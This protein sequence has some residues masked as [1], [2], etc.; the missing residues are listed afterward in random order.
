MFYRR[1]IFIYDILYNPFEEISIIEWK[2]HNVPLHCGHLSYV[3]ECEIRLF[4]RVTFQQL[5]LRIEFSEI[6]AYIYSVYL[7]QTPDQ[8]LSIENSPNCSIISNTM[9][10]IAELSDPLCSTYQHG[11]RQEGF[12]HLQR[13]PDLTPITDLNTKRPCVFNLMVCDVTFHPPL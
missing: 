2:L 12:L 3:F 13:L 4:T 6:H 8:L 9:L 1:D 10:N 11:C 5:T 7:L